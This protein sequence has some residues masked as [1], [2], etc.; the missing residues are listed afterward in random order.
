MSYAT[1]WAQSCSDAPRVFAIQPTQLSQALLV[2]ARQSG[3]SIVFDPAAARGFS[4]QSVLG[5]MPPRTALRLL[6]RDLPLRFDTAAGGMVTVTRAPHAAAAGTP[7]TAVASPAGP[8]LKGTHIEDVVVS[9]DAPVG[10]RIRGADFIGFAQTDIITAV[11]LQR[12]GRQSI[13]EVLRS[14]PAVSGNSTSTLVTNGGDGTA[15]VTLRGLPAA[16]TLVLIDG[17]RTNPDGLNGKSVDLN[18]LPLG[19]VERI[20]VLKDGA[21]SAYGSD[22]IAGVVN[23]VTR[24]AID[25]VA[26]DVYE[27]VSQRA[28]LH[29]RQLSA[30]GGF[31][32]DGGAFSWG[33][34]RY[35]QSDIKS[36]DRGTSRSADGRGRGGIDQRSSATPYPRVVLDDASFI[37]LRP[38]EV[39]TG[40]LPFRAATPED[41]YNFRAATSAVV[42]SARW[43]LF[44]R[45][46]VA[47]RFGQLRADLL[48]NHTES[49]NRLA[50]LPVFTALEALPLPIA[51]DQ[52]YNLFG[53]ELTD[54]RRRAV[55]LGARRDRNH[56]DTWRGDVSLENS[57]GRVDS[58]LQLGYHVTD[59]AEVRD[60]LIDGARLQRALGPPAGCNLPCVPVDLLGGPG[61]I[62]PPM[63][64]YVAATARANGQTTLLNLSGDVSSDIGPWPAGNVRAGA[65][66]DVRRE[67]IHTAPDALTRS[68]NALGGAGFGPTRGH[69][70]IA[71]LY[72]EALLPLARDRPG[73]TSLDASIA[74]RWSYYSDFGTTLNPKVALRYR[75]QQPWLLRA[76]YGS[77]FRAPTLQQLYIANAASF[78]FLND[79]CANRVNLGVYTGCRQ[80]SDPALTQFLTLTGG[81]RHLAP[82]SSRTTTIGA[83]WTPAGFSLGID[84]YRIQQ[85]KVV[86]AN[87]QY[88]VNQNARYARFPD[89]VVRDAQGNIK[90]VF[91]H[92]LNIGRRD[93]AGFD[94]N[95][96]WRLPASSLG[97]VELAA[98][99]AYIQQFEDRLSPGAPVVDHA[100]TFSDEASSGNGALPRWKADAGLLWL[101]GNWELRY[102]LFF[103]SALTET[104][105][106]IEAQRTIKTWYSHSLQLAYDGPLPFNARVAVGVNNLFD[107]APP[108]S[109]AAFNDSFDARTYDLSGRFWYVRFSGDVR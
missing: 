50:P 16:N 7:V 28:D 103:V 66:F 85:H 82:E 90:S 73:I 9:A 31:Q 52:R 100:G 35:N 12:S 39:Q 10:S 86:D 95:A 67:A 29:T 55:E 53:V 63:I 87:A 83:V 26:L 104:V 78:Q 22:A 8:D 81:E 38:D 99:G 15:T 32:I 2:F 97:N 60:R 96:K 18:S 45:T 68:G 27:G 37:R 56:S 93:L 34:S 109:A 14:L 64:E 51:A 72:A 5:T 1:A 3:C 105:P 54:V 75:P 84:Y 25:G 30:A 101:R 46:T 98:S 79:P 20:E 59:A 106:F 47:T 92:A 6:L 65:G 23:I 48:R 71:E 13:G 57:G 94:L 17:H 24:R 44:A 102:D 107:K 41:R 49:E 61:S 76:S 77:G 62:T 11:D 43:S 88:I 91:A 42:P 19:I 36:R 69:R 40:A 74:G 89:R 80:V 58:A 4:T 108:F 21:A 33:A 70:D